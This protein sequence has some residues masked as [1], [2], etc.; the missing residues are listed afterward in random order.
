MSEAEASPHRIK[1]LVLE[2]RADDPR[3]ASRLQRLLGE[4]H[5]REIAPLLARLCDELGGGDRSLRIDRLALDLGEVDAEDFEASFMRALRRELPRALTRALDAEA[6]TPADPCPELEA[7]A[8]FA[9]TGTLPWWSPTASPTLLRD[10]LALL[11]AREPTR[12]TALL[13]EL[14]AEPTTLARLATH[15]DDP[16]LAAVLT[17]LAGRPGAPVYAALQ[18]AAAA[19]PP[20][21]RLP[22]GRRRAALWQAVLTTAARAD[23]TLPSAELH[24][25]ALAEL[26][27]RTGV[28]LRD[29]PALRERRLAHAL[30]AA[31]RALAGGDALPRVLTRLRALAAATPEPDDRARWLATHV[32]GAVDDAAQALAELEGVV[33]AAVAPDLRT[34]LADAL[35]AASSH[36]TNTG[37][38]GHP[39]RTTP[40]APGHPARTTPAASPGPATHAPA[41]PRASPA[42]RESPPGTSSASRSEPRDLYPP[43]SPGAVTGAP[44]STAPPPTQ[45]APKDHP[46]SPLSPPAVL[47]PETTPSLPP[48]LFTTVDRSAH[49][50]DPSSHPEAPPSPSSVATEIHARPA[51]SEPSP[52]SRPPPIQSQHADT[53]TNRSH[54]AAAQRAT[55]S[56]PAPD[57]TA[58]VAPPAAEPPQPAD[59]TAFTNTDPSPGSRPTK[60]SRPVTNATPRATADASF[61]RKT[62]DST[63]I[64]ATL[65]SAAIAPRTTD[66][67]VLTHQR[68][69]SNPIS[70]TIVDSPSLFPTIADS[71]PVPRASEDSDPLART[72][73]DSRTTSLPS[74]S[75]A[76]GP[77]S[78]PD[79]APLVSP[80]TAALAQHATTPALVQLAAR[81]CEHAPDVGD[82]IALASRLVDA[83]RT[84]A[85]ARDELERGLAAL[86]EPTATPPQDLARTLTAALRGALLTHAQAERRPAPRPPR[87]R[88]A[89]PLL[90][91]GF[92]AADEYAV[93]DAGLVIL[94]PFLAHFFRALGLVEGKEFRDEPARQRA[95]GLLRVVATGDLDVVEYQLPLAKVLCGLGVEDPVDLGPPASD[96]EVAECERLLGAVT[97]RAPI[98]QRMS[99]AALRGN[100]L[101]R[102]GLLG[103]RDGAWLLRVER[104]THDVVL[105][106]FPWGFEW[107]KLPWM[108]AAIR[109]EW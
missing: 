101:V 64:P 5:A 80:S 63:A 103:A 10:G 7:L 83:L 95:A 4:L 109:V 31:A 105:D 34:P 30:A 48:A 3:E 94:W 39:A 108:A 86:A 27:A 98:V 18:A 26:A 58:P 38:P 43:T 70:H 67:T 104:R 16:A 45:A 8:V 93:G 100:F 36:A 24:L 35:R 84:G 62:A 82:P 11:L 59:S 12:L 102:D 2:L 33:G 90:D 53:P 66:S 14:A 50:S 22:P 37:A 78:R 54:P 55:P 49:T 60:D 28:D 47:A 25:R 77:V 71:P 87:P 15:F 79:A 44:T 88:P 6:A 40:G 73:H 72:S 106:R 97:A 29:A 85:L 96:D 20:L 75:S 51:R 52:T 76:G 32:V 99:A 81:L 23:A 1:R 89:R 68:T 65:D 107:V 41:V 21:Q 17:L 91:L 9:R 42:I 61:P 56:R 57:L 74:L 92:S 46:G 69:D 13:A 19:S